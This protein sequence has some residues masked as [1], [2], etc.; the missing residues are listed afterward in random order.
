MSLTI[1]LGYTRNTT[2]KNVA[3]PDQAAS[4]W[5]PGKLQGQAEAKNNQAEYVNITSPVDRV[6]TC[7]IWR[8]KIDDVYKGTGINPVDQAPHT[9]GISIGRKLS[10][11]YKITDSVTN[12]SVIVPISGTITITTGVHEAMSANVI[13]AFLKDVVAQLYP[14]ASIT[15]NQIARQ[16][17]GSLG[18]IDETT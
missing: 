14:T 7:D 16:L 4:Q 5:A 13:E 2:T 10:A 3:I 18:Y 11:K 17:S 15:S 9:D 6:A 1:D 12:E 8:R